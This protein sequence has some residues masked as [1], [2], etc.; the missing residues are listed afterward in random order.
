MKAGKWVSYYYE[1][2]IPDEELEGETES[3]KRDDIVMKLRKA[4][5]DVGFPS[6]HVV[7]SDRSSEIEIEYTDGRMTTIP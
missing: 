2:H 3:E 1:V 4:I 7:H 5:S 6:E